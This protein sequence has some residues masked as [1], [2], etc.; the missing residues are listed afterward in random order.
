[1]STESPHS[2]PNPEASVLSV[3]LKIA[4]GRGFEPSRRF[5][6][7]KAGVQVVLLIPPVVL[8]RCVFL[9]RTRIKCVS[10]PPAH[11]MI[12]VTAAARWDTL[13]S[14]AS[15]L[16]VL[17]AA[18]RNRQQKALLLLPDRIRSPL[19][20]MHM[21][22]GSQR[23]LLSVQPLQVHLLLL[24]RGG[25]SAGLDQHPYGQHSHPAPPTDPHCHTH[26]DYGICCCRVSGLA[27][28]AITDPC[29]APE[30]AEPEAMG[31]PGMGLGNGGRCALSA[32]TKQTLTPAPVT[33]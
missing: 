19:T 26:L 28:I 10:S 16:P 3:G 30:V 31:R 8:L 13:K 2:V 23:G 21:R 4:R 14:P 12:Y 15:P 32:V 11:L 22:V 27:L 29:Q 6:L 18:R 33:P 24:A 20:W 17:T 5:H 25:G 9:L 1:M 7:G